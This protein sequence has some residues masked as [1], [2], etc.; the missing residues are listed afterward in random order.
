MNNANRPVRERSPFLF[1]RGASGDG[2]G[3]LAAIPLL[4]APGPGTAN[5]TGTAN[6]VVTSSAGTGRLYVGIVTN[7]GSCTDAQL[8]AGSGG[9]LVA[10][11]TSNQAITTSGIQ[12]VATIT[13]LTT[14]TLYQIKFLSVVEGISSA[15]ASVN[16]T[17][18]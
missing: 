16:L 4:S 12:T 9:N 3:V 18:T 2:G 7:T 15:Q 10:G 11:S 13:G 14:G 8:I 17:T 6:A 1:G 5:T